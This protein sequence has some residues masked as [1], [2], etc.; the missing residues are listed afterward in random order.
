MG[1][2]RYLDINRLLAFVGG[3]LSNPRVV[4]G[5]WHGNPT[6]LLMTLDGIEMDVDDFEGTG[7][8]NTPVTPTSEDSDEE[9]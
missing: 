1:Q 3:V 8:P 4:R 7:A 9:E 5:D 2:D 6:D